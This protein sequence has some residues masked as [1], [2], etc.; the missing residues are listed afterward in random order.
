MAVEGLIEG[1]VAG[2]VGGQ[3]LGAPVP[4]TD[5]PVGVIFSG[6]WPDE[7]EEL[8]SL[9]RPDVFCVGFVV[10]RSQPQQHTQLDM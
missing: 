9:Y 6:I 10:S 3:G 4:S 2:A 8:P 1:V 7:P 5:D